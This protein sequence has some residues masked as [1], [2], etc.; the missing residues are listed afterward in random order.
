V[1]AAYLYNVSKKLREEVE[2]LLYRTRNSKELTDKIKDATVPD[3]VK[4]LKALNRVED[5]ADCICIYYGWRSQFGGN[6]KNKWSDE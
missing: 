6:S 1:S 5:T 2:D 4:S 3:L